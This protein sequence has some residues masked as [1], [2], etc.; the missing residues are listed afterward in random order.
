ME[1]LLDKHKKD[2]DALKF[3]VD[4]NDQ[5]ERRDTLILSGSNLPILSSNENC[6]TI[7]RDSISSHTSLAIHDNDISIAHRN[8]R[9]DKRKMIFKLCKRDLMSDILMPTN[10]QG[11]P[12]I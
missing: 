8:V 10:N 1:V 9:Q 6:K 4:T 12:S 5:N 3:D 11:F 2:V 7:V